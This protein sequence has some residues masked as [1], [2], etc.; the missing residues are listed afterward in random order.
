MGPKISR[1]AISKNREKEVA[2]SLSLQSRQQPEHRSL[3]GHYSCPPCRPA[4]VRELLRLWSAGEEMPAYG[5][6]PILWSFPLM[7][8]TT[9]MSGKDGT[10]GLLCKPRA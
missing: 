5:P 4:V 9:R 8:H 3:F 10:E 7:R 6:T 1:A 2:P